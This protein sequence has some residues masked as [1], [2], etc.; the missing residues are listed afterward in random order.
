MAQAAGLLCNGS[1]ENHGVIGLLDV[2]DLEE[3]VLIVME[4]PG[5]SMSIFDFVEQRDGQISEREAKSILKQVVD[6]AL[7]MHNNGIFHQDI[8]G[9]NVLVSP[10][11]TSLPIRIIDF[12]CG[13]FVLDQPYSE[14]CGTSGYE[15]PEVLE[16]TEYHAEPTTVWQIGAMLRFIFNYK[17][18]I[19]NNYNF[20]S[21]ECI[22]FM[23]Q[24]QT[25]YPK[26]R[27]GLDK[28]QRH[29]WLQ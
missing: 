1:K 19:Y 18:Y 26:Q 6:A 16:Q 11:T 15:P 3:E 2:Y 7:L 14:F 13:G 20:L 23:S 25:F 8:K 10:E 4:H 9:E 28:L 22:D 12:G 24:C 27:P 21:Q 29:P 5:K 17:Y